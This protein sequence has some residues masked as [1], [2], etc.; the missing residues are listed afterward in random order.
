MVPKDVP[1]LITR[2]CEQVGSRDREA[3]RLQL[4]LNVLMS[5]PWSREPMSLVLKEDEGDGPRS[6][7]ASGGWKSQQHGRVPGS[8]EGASPA[9][10]LALAQ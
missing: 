3:L 4:E 10:T 5:Q 8:A 2:T 1:V 7:G 9:N 6:V